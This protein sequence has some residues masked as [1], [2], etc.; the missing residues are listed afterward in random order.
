LIDTAI[1]ILTHHSDTDQIFAALQAGASGYL[2]K[3]ASFAQLALAI[4][5]AAQG[6]ML[7]PAPV[8]RKVLGHFNQTLAAEDFNL[9]PRELEVLLLMT[10]GFRHEQ[11]S[12]KLLRS[13][14]TIGNHI[15]NIYRKLH[16]HSA[17]EAVAK[18]RKHGLIQWA[19]RHFI[20]H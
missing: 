2:V 13:P 17:L 9:T 7:L 19:K 18:A 6:G 8:A 11:I 5:E 15:R 1:V 20:P 16:V 12:E 4:A 3:N 14:Y 10:E